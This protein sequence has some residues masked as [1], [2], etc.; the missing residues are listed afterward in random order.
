MDSYIKEGSKVIHESNLNQLLTVL[1]RHGDQVLL[2]NNEF[3][4]V[5]EVDLAETEKLKR[6][7]AW[8]VS[9]IRE[10]G[11]N[12]SVPREIEELLDTDEIYSQGAP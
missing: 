3:A 12:I 11:L 6:I 2:S 8:T 4:W 5:S 1:S 9:V 7:L 10:K